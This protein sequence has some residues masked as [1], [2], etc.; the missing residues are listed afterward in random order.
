[1]AKRQR[2]D[3]IS[4]LQ[5]IGIAY[6]DAAAVRR[7]SMTLQRWHEL[8]CGD[9]N[10][11]AS[12]VIERDGDEPDSPPYLVTHSHAKEGKTRRHRVPDRETGARR[13]LGVIMSRYP[14][15][16]AYVQGDPRGASLYVLAPDMLR[17][18][19]T[20]DCYYSR[21]VAVYKES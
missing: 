5:R 14:G 11:Y 6:D 4:A 21:G 10:D 9:S 12:W 2:Y 20:L 19:T 16:A 13:R 3:S 17:A 1:M 15:F 7:I 18:D 8:E